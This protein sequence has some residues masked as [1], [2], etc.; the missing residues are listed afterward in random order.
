MEYVTKRNGLLEEVDFQKVYNRI[1]KMTF[2]LS[3]D[4]INVHAISKAVINGIYNKVP[5]SE[6]DN[7]TVKVAGA[8][9][10]EH[11]DYGILA[12]R[13]ALS[14][15]K[16]STP[17]RFSD[18]VKILYNY[19]HPRVGGATPV[20]SKELYEVVVADPSLWDSMVDE[21]RDWNYNIFAV[22]TLKK[23]Y[24][25]RCGDRVV[26]TPQFMHLRVALGIN[27]SKDGSSVDV[28][29]VRKTYDAT[30]TFLYTHASPTIFNS[31][32]PNPQLASC[33]L[34]KNKGD[35]IEGIYSTLTESALISKMAGGIGVS[36]HDV[37]SAGAYIKGNNGTA[38]GIVP[39]L[40][41]FN[42]TARYV[43]QGG[44]RKGA[45]AVY[46]E[47]HHADVLDFLDLRKGH[48]AEERRCK[49]I[50]TAMWLSDLFMERCVENAEW[51]LFDPS[52]APGLHEVYGEEYKRLYTQYEREGRGIR[53][54]KARDLH[55]AIAVSMI[56]TGTPYC[57]NKDQVNRLSNQK[58]LG[59]IQS[60]NLCA[61]IT[62]Y[63]SVEET[64]VCQLASVNLSAFVR[65]DGTYDYDGLADI[66]SLAIKNLNKIIDVGIYP[67]QTA[68]NSMERHRP[69]GLGINALQDVYFKMGLPFDSAEAE[70]MNRNMCEAVYFGAVRQSVEEAKLHGPY[71]SYKDS[72]A[73]QGLLQFDMW[74][75]RTVNTSVKD[76]ALFERLARSTLGWGDRWEGLR[77][78]MAKY[79][80]RNSL[81]TAYMPTA[82]S[83]T[84]L[85]VYECFEPQT[86]NIYRRSVLS[87]EFAVVNK[88]LVN[89]LI[90][91]GIWNEETRNSILANDGSV[92][93]LPQLP[94]K[95][96]DVYKTV[97]ELSM[98][99]IID[100]A[101]D[102]SQ[103]VDQSQS[104]NM[105]LKNP[106]VAKLYGMM[107]YSWSRGLK[108]M[109]YYLRSRAASEAQRFTV[110]LKQDECL[111]CSA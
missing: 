70:Q 5:T 31:G 72:P 85:G 7:L 69:L 103:Y 98:K 63:T 21:S 67:V 82:S 111:S 105:F 97:W 68:R 80:L 27:I 1:D 28:E 53:T 42:E 34:I 37:R 108:T 43:N 3:K 55:K 26:E 110:S 92:Q 74:R 101:F 109:S 95:L 89:D 32:T 84:L 46:L 29:G 2:G 57:L 17:A 52:S 14:N 30:S 22:E 93:Q 10:V 19:H 23:S 38:D 11:P 35:S 40:R 94:P 61:E 64:S 36:F 62:E 60:S 6:L 44:R 59:T 65:E 106:T 25:L 90:K 104:L 16:K 76:P 75:D 66:S 56:E 41:L 13:I 4:H 8:K 81:L 24:L 79:G 102:R 15:L 91:L 99:P 96:K 39:A 20:V 100:Q 18:A 77:S 54:I 50:F 83:A 86:A 71:S 49:D 48:G 12:G 47:P 45:I 88:Y 58:N 73:S 107:M 87:G 78:E 9:T 33:F 51:T